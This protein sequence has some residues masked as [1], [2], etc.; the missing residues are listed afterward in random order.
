MLAGARAGCTDSAVG[1]AVA[2]GVPAPVD[3][4]AEDWAWGD[5]SGGVKAD[6]GTAA[7]VAALGLLAEEGE[8]AGGDLRRG[9]IAGDNF[10]S[11]MWSSTASQ[12]CLN[13]LNLGRPIMDGT[14]EPVLVRKV[15]SISECDTLCTRD[16]K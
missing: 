9:Y 15:I 7:A 1:T 8:E 11:C 3:D 13:K 10:V 6:T 12:T 5:G 2:V 14:G 16:S 4:V